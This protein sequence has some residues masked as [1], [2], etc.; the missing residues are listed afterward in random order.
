M[1]QIVHVVRRAVVQRDLQTIIVV[2]HKRNSY[3]IVEAISDRQTINFQINN[4]PFNQYTVSF[5][6]GVERHS[7]V[8]CCSVVMASCIYVT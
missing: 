1:Q 2:T 5:T 3:Q 8:V 7:G 6:N 4:V